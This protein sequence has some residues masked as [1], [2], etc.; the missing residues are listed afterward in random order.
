MNQ[1]EDLYKNNN[2]YWGTLPSKTCYRVLELMPPDK[3]I[4]LLDIGCGEGQNALFFARNGYQVSA[5]DLSKTGVEKTRKRAQQIGL[6]ID[7]FE[8]DLLTYRLSDH[9]DIL[10]SS[11]VLHYIPQELR[12]EIFKN[13][14][15]HT[16]TDGIHSF[17]VLVKK[18]FIRTAPDSEPTAQLWF[19]GE[20][21]SKYRDW[22]IEYCTEEIFDCMSSGVPHKH[23]VNRVIARNIK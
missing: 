17:N 7:A 1:Y 16:N 19:S 2:N 21:F 3:P 4:K 14:R 13:Y 23:A 8:A 12:N 22:K 15:E 11:G 20:L 10:F 18:P 5:F 9:F 6:K